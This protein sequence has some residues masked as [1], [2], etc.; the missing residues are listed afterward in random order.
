MNEDVGVQLG[1]EEQGQRARV[2]LAEAA[3]LHGAGEVADHD[4]E[5]A[6][7]R[8]LFIVRVERNDHRGL[9]RVLVHLH[10]D[11][12]TDDLHDERDEL[13][14]E[15]AQDDARIGIARRAAELLD[16]RGHA[17]VRA[18]H[19]RGEEGLLGVE[20][21]EDGGRRDAE[22]PGDVGQRG[23]AESLLREDGAGGVEKL[24]AADAWWSS[25]VRK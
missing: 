7:R 6:A 12:R 20:V 11:G 21:A 3:R 4:G 24:L 19:G 17:D 23:A 14:G 22:R 8:A 1:D 16:I 9:P 13:L 18:A 15:A 5:A 2:G 10:G 25:H